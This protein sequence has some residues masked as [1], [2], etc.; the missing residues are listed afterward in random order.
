MRKITHAEA[1]SIKKPGMYRASETLFLRVGY[2]GGKSWIQRLTINGARRD[3]GL[4]SFS[5]VSLAEAREIAHQNRRLARIEKRDPLAEKRR[6]KTPTF[7][8]AAERFHEANRPR[9]RA[10]KH[11][12]NWMQIMSKYAFPEIGERR[13]DELHQADVLQILTP[14]W[15]AKA[16]TAKRLRRFIRSVFAWAQAHGYR[17]SNP[18]GEGIDAA[19]PKMPKVRANF[20]AL[21]YAEIPEAIETI[22]ASGAS[23][24]AKAAFRF[25]I[26][27]A[28]RSGEVRGATWDEID[29]ESKTWRIPGE[30]MKSG[31][32]HRVPLSDEAVAVLEQARVIADGSDLIFPSP[33]K[34]GKPLS[35]MSLTKLLRDVGLAGKATIHGMRS[36]FRD[37]CAETGKPRE[38]AEAALAHVVAG[39]EGSYFRSD[40]FEQRREIMQAWSDFLK[41]C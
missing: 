30:R 38:L 15:T 17:E 6:A 8:E 35:D 18:A 10:E 11:A 25:L 2:A 28:A 37:W 31:R 36:A 12:K 9:W 13:V 4:G 33:V 14:I 41:V 24:S 7:K 16:E 29:L 32:E 26:L 5:L 1:K 23:L 20:R 39:I 19:L 40:L 3:I 22:E 27:T 21:P 34:P